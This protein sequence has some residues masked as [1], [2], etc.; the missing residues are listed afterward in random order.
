MSPVKRVALFTMSDTVMINLVLGLKRAFEAMGIEVVTGFDYLNGHRMRMLVDWFKPDFILEVNRSRNQIVDFDDKIHHIGWLEASYRPNGQRIDQGWGGSDLTYCNLDPLQMGVSRQQAPRWEILHFAMDEK[1]YFPFGAPPVWDVTTIGYLGRPIQPQ[2][3]AAVLSTGGV[4]LMFGE[5]CAALAADGLAETDFD[6]DRL[7][8]CVL[9]LLRGKKS[10]YRPDEAYYQILTLLDNRVLRACGRA[11]NLK[12]ILRVTR[13]IK[14]FGGGGWAED[15]TLRP[16]YV[17]PLFRPSE[18]SAIVNLSRLVYHYGR[19]SMHERVMEAMCCGVPPLVNRT[20][21][22]DRPFG[23]DSYFNDGDHFFYYDDDNIGDV[24]GRLL[25][26][27]N[28][29]RRVG[30]QARARILERHLWHHRAEQI[31]ADFQSL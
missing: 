26:D 27:E 22:D 28:L 17:G 2:E 16:F 30:E 6:S 19:I 1:T 12:R 10:D 5:I 31:L 7:Q 21:Y 25:K 24:V 4:S 18:K 9:G 23:I 15:P 13:E 29:R 20:P 8:N 11:D 14:I 3:L